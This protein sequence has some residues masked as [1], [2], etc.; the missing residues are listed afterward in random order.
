MYL[1]I[2]CWLCAVNKHQS[3]LSKLCQLC[4]LCGCHI[5][6]NICISIR[7]LITWPFS[8]QPG[9]WYLPFSLLGGSGR[10]FGLTFIYLLSGYHCWLSALDSA[11]YKAFYVMAL[12]GGVSFVS[13]IMRIGNGEKGNAYLQSRCKHLH[14]H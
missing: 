10:H 9:F 1:C 5:I 7:I 6:V 14:I 11:P 2:K 4:S 13:K 12:I 8:R 3:Q